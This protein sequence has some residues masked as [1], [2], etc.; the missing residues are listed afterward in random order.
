PCSPG[1]KQ[2]ALWPEPASCNA[3]GVVAVMASVPAAPAPSAVPYRLDAV[4]CERAA[5]SDP[6]Q[7]YSSST[8]GAPPRSGGAHPSRPHCPRPGRVAP[9]AAGAS[10]GAEEAQIG[11]RAEGAPVPAAPA[12]WENPPAADVDLTGAVTPRL[13]RSL[14]WPAQ[15]L[16]RM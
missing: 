14:C 2:L 11:A 6:P 1:A 7:A 8:R 12:P 5:T 9:D 4:A 16:E 15:V 3:L 10:R 13:K